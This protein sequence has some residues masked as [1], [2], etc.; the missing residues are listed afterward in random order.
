MK[1]NTSPTKK[2]LRAAACL[3]LLLILVVDLFMDHT[4]KWLSGENKSI[5][6]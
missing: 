6:N 2:E 3:L 1:A 4:T 5:P